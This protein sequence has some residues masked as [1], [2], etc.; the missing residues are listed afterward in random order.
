MELCFP[1]DPHL[2]V[3]CEIRM[4]CMVSGGVARI[5]LNVCDQAQNN[6]IMK[7]MSAGGARRQEKPQ[8]LKKMDRK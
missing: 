3:P 6:C 1:E 7:G 5:I 8:F 2:S 4:V